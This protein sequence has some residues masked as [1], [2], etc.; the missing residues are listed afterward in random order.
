MRI[1]IPT[2]VNQA[3]DAFEYGP[4][5]AATVM[6]TASA[7]ALAVAV[8]MDAVLV[9]IAAVAVG[10]AVFL[11][12]AFKTREAGLREELRQRDYDLAA[13]DAE[14]ARLSAG[15]PAAP[16][17]QLLAIGESGELT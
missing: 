5:A 1:R 12:G 14:I 13:K 8:V 7:G 6:A 2:R 16:T 9:G 15:D 4:R 11:I 10:W 17:A 3:L